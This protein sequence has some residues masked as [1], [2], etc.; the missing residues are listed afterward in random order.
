MLYKI[1]DSCCLYNEGK[2]LKDVSW[3][4]YTKSISIWNWNLEEKI[5]ITKN[6]GI[7]L[8]ERY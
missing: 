1:S 3:N 5:I 2:V 8:L 7:D 6:R 4:G